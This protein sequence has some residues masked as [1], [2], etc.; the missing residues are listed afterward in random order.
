MVVQ[1]SARL[2]DDF[3]GPTHEKKHESLL[4][5]AASTFEKT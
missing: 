5:A 4:R 1:V 2:Q 3:K